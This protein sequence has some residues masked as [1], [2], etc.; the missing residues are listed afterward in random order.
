M[1]RK[2]SSRGGSRRKGGAARKGRGGRLW[3]GLGLL[4]LAVG[5]V[6][7]YLVQSLPVPRG[8]GDLGMV[9]SPTARLEELLGPLDP[10]GVRVQVASGR[11]AR[12]FSSRLA[13]VAAAAPSGDLTLEPWS[14]TSQ[15]LLGAVV[16]EGRRYPLRL[17]WDLP[18]VK[19]VPQ[20]AVVID[21]MG[22][23]LELERQFLDLPLEITPSLLPHLHHTGEV[24]AYA[25]ARGREFLLHL[26][27]QP[28]DYPRQNPGEG[29]ILEGMDEAQARA[30][31]RALLRAV[32]GAAG[33]NNHMGSRLT[34]LREPMTWVLDELRA[35]GLF[36]LDSVT[37][38]ESVGVEVARELGLGWARRDVFLDNVREVAAV[39]EQ[40]DK[41]AAL[42]RERGTAVAIGH[43]HRATLQAL[44]EWA[45][46][47]RA[48]GV[49]VV[50]LGRLVRRGGGA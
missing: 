20:L 32:P 5:V 4:V 31:V 15:A 14:Q 8:G 16:V 41:A 35:E 24:A 7:T 44:A 45:P 33:A 29:A 9:R 6:G 2:G 38:G 25:A 12:E 27:M 42:A 1:T 36:F 48:A 17:E 22:R 49:R 47:L 40:L 26:P 19:H 10:A 34:E 13:E 50:P 37:T 18:G 28:R 46:R 23:N 11:G 39:G 21:D 3:W 30:G 43:P